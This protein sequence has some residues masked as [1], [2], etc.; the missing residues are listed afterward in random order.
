MVFVLSRIGIITFVFKLK[1]MKNFEKY[2]SIATSFNSGK[3]LIKACMNDSDLALFIYVSLN[4][5]VEF[6]SIDVDDVLELKISSTTLHNTAMIL[7]G[8]LSISMD[9]KSNVVADAFE[10][11]TNYIDTGKIDMDEWELHVSNLRKE[12]KQMMYQKELEKL[13][14]IE[15]C[16]KVMLLDAFEC[17]SQVAHKFDALRKS[18]F[19]SGTYLLKF[20]LKELI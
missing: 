11:K 17:Y 1:K 12:A 9:F 5:G 10:Y 3:E 13:E 2:I 20:L 19:N 16:I 7:A 15:V 8:K 14:I 18:G 6:P 4:E